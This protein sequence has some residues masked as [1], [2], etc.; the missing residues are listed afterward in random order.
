MS[1]NVRVWIPA[2]LRALTAGQEV[3][4]VPSGTLQQILDN[5]EEQYPGLRERLCDQTGLRPGLAVAI[6]GQIAARGL[7]QQV[8]AGS[9]VHFLPAIGGG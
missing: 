1:A 4:S 2:P 6:N 3:V 8:P 7:W 5:L 9:E